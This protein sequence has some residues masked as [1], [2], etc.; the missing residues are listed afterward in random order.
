MTRQWC[1]E[2]ETLTHGR[3]SSSCGDWPEPHSRHRR[4]CHWLGEAE[5]RKR[6]HHRRRGWCWWLGERVRRRRTPFSWGFGTGGAHRLGRKKYFIHKE[7]R[8]QQ[9]RASQCRISVENRC[10]R[11]GRRKAR[12]RTRGLWFAGKS[13]GLGP[14]LPALLA[15]GPSQC[16]GS[17]P[18]NSTSTEAGRVRGITRHVLGFHVYPR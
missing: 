18:K 7:G 11:V 13:W 15:P 3:P 14:T 5:G 17:A 10:V 4:R 1:R 9:S 8:E 2:S 12:C 16:P 6:W